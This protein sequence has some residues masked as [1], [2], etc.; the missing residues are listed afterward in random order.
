MPKYKIIIEYDGSNYVGWQRQENGMSIQESIENSIHKLTGE[1]ITLFGAG[2]TDAGVHAIGQ[3][4]HFSLKKN[5]YTK[6]IR[7]GLNQHLRP[8]PIAILKADEIEKDFH[9]RFSA[10]KRT[11][12]YFITNRR[13]PLAINKNKSWAVFKK[14]DIK[15]MQFESNFF[16]GKNNLESFRS[17]NCQSKSAI[18]TIDEIKILEQNN[19]IKIKVVAKSFLHSQVRIMTGT[20]VDIGKGKIT[21]S[22]KNIIENKNRSLAGIT[23]PACGLYLIKVDY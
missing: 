15:K 16:L 1:K 14:L 4:A 6:N 3:V 18:K 2:R 12:E 10:K 23:A 22:I 17:I 9:S 21:Q 5:F 19:N 11:Y 7:D 13:A 20:L 8:Q